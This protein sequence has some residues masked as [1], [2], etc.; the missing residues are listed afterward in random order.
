[1]RRARG[2]NS[3]DELC[4]AS[5][6][7]EAQSSR[8]TQCSRSKITALYWSLTAKHDLWSW[9]VQLLRT[10]R[11][12][13][14]VCTQHKYAGAGCRPSRRERLKVSK[15]TRIKTTTAPLNAVCWRGFEVLPVRHPAENCS[16]TA[17]SAIRR[18]AAGPA[19][20]CGPA[21]TAS[22]GTRQDPRDSAAGRSASLPW[23]WRQDFSVCS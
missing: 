11:G 19:T 10:D 23:K 3:G 1:M 9:V 4:A 13:V 6:P 7:C 15:R 18:Q 14:Q 12:S 17:A 21:S 16:G 5:E 22:P 8:T 2:A 20:R